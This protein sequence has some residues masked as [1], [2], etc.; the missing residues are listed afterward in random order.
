MPIKLV[1][2]DLDET[3]VHAR[4]EPLSRPADLRFEDYF[5]YIRPYAADLVRF[6]STKFSIAV[7]SSANP[8]YVEFITS[9]LFGAQYPLLFRWDVQKCVQKVDSRTNGYVYIKDLRKVMKHGY[10]VEEI[11]IVD[12]SP[13]KIQR[14][15]R[16][17]LVVEPFHGDRQDQELRTV[18]TTLAQLPA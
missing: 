17:H 3:L 1:I 13:E 12:D 4:L 18:I 16:S 9:A 2:F 14:Q 10:Q 6:A 5:I 8:D 11:L 15:P 7:W